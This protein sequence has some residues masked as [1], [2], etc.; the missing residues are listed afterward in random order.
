[1][2]KYCTDKF[3][4]FVFLLILIWQNTVIAIL[5]K[6][7]AIFPKFVRCSNS[8]LVIYVILCSTGTTLAAKEMTRA[9]QSSLIVGNISSSISLF[10]IKKLQVNHRKL[11]T[12]L[13]DHT[14][15]RRPAA[16]PIS[17]PGL[18]MPALQSSCF[19]CY[20]GV[21]LETIPIREEFISWTKDQMLLYSLIV[22]FL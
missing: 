2:F 18:I 20:W 1:M 14:G 22:K 8:L 16:G 12:V 5:S 4:H 19:L 13:P 7:K 6:T 10:L 11:L 17:S 15:L 3:S 9:Q 21:D